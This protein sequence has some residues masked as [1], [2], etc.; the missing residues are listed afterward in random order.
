MVRNRA[1]ALFSLR[2]DFGPRSIAQ[3][4]A[5]PAVLADGA[6]IVSWRLGAY[7]PT[8]ALVSLDGDAAATLTGAT[9]YGFLGG[10]INEWRYIA[11]LNNGTAIPIAGAGVGFVQA[12]N[13]P[14]GFDA[15]TIVGTLS[16]GNLLQQYIPVEYIS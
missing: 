3:L 7:G 13:I 11:V 8:Q 10:S 16:A 14:A 4:A 12:I 2:V 9:L 1:Q 6:S 15:L 5:I